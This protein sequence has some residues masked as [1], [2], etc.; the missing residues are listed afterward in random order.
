[1]T[2]I[3]HIMREDRITLKIWNDMFSEVDLSDISIR[4][5]IW[6]LSDTNPNEKLRK[7]L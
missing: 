6:M 3:S 7:S 1:M 4:S 2:D 5:K